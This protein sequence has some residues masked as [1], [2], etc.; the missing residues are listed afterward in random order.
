MRRLAILSSIILLVLLSSVSVTGCQQQAPTP[1]PAPTPEAATEHQ[2]TITNSGFEP[3]EINIKAKD[4]VT[5][6]NQDTE[7]HTVAG[8][9]FDSGD[10]EPGE[11]YSKTFTKT[12]ILNYLCNYHPSEKGKIIITK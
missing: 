8:G 10:M 11:T 3:P 9:I 4:T 2:I 7:H 5:W 12:G 6:T 1:T